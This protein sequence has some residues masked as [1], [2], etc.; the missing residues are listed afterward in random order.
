M[1]RA[2]F[3]FIGRV[4]DTLRLVLGRLLFVLI[5]GIILYLLF[6]SP[7]QMRVP[8]QAALVL[9]PAGMITEQR[10]PPTPAD[11]LLGPAVPPGSVLDELVSA[12]QTAA[13]DN[14]ITALVIDV[15]DLIGV[16]PAHLETLG[17][18]L[19][20]F[21]TSDKPIYAYGEYFGQ[22][23]YALASYADEIMLHPMGSLMINGYG[24]NQLFFRDL[25][26]KLRVNVHIFRAGE[27]KSA[28][29]PF[30]RMDMSDEARADSQALLDA[31]WDRYVE[32][33]SA[34]RGL[35][36]DALQAYADNFP[37][38]LN[39]AGGDMAR[40]AFEQGL[41]DNIA[42]VDSFRRQVAARVGAENGSFKQIHYRDYLFATP[43]MTPV[44]ADQ[45]GVIVAQGTIMPGAQPGGFMGADTVIDLIRQAQ[46]DS[47]IKALVLRMDSPGGSAIASEQIRAALTQVQLADKPVVISMG[48]TA[49]SGGYWIS[50]TADE[51]WA[52]PA[53]ITGS[54]GVI[55]VIPTFENALDGLGIGVDGVGTTNLS[56]S[57][58]PLSG[59][60]D[61]MRDVFQ[62]SIDDTYQR[63]LQ[64]VADGRNMSL[65]EVDS[66]AQGR[67]WTGEQAMELGLVD[68]MGDLDRA[69]ASAAALAGLTAWQT[70]TIERPLSFGEQLLRQ[71]VDNMGGA[72]V[73]GGVRSALQGAGGW[74]FS[75]VPGLLPGLPQA[76]R[77]RWQ[78]MLSLILPADFAPQRLRTLMVCEQCL[79][80]QP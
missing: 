69:V 72:Q 19:A 53:T 12:L 66:I 30:T 32:R 76:E 49:A 9:A 24:G 50:A 21:K 16:S 60:N 67:V 57:G 78:A 13:T 11:I 75:G 20:Q 55:G 80:T 59:L 74:S 7:A 70:V 5:F 33:V 10:G 56:R 2:F 63:F 26:E 54:I 18:A 6:S 39:A 61:A 4:I 62:N 77:L 73:L 68:G 44:S 17:D 46:L 28:A 34:N 40:V 65:A 42:G 25:L 37:A 47:S 29:E 79:M 27:F 71:A 31:L 35:S 43:Q 48:S 14:R 41:V 52:S 15:S 51:I 64:L 45:I 23:Q 1:M 8:S 22:G 3:S 58:D 36:A 38:L